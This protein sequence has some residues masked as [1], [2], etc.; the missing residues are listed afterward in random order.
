MMK[1]TDI[2]NRI[3]ISYY[4]TSFLCH[5][6]IKG[7]KWGVR[8]YQNPDGSYT[9]AGKKRRGTSS[10][11]QDFGTKCNAFL[12]GSTSAIR[13]RDA[14]Q[15]QQNRE[16]SALHR[17]SNPYDSERHLTKEA[18][19]YLKKVDTITQKY[20][21]AIRNLELDHIKEMKA[22]RRTIF[23]DP[24]I[25]NDVGAIRKLHSK[26]E[27]VERDTISENSELANQ[28][29]NSYKKQ[30]GNDEYG[31]YHYEWRE[32]NKAYDAANSRFKKETED[33]RKEYRVLSNRISKAIVN[34][35]GI[36]PSEKRSAME[37]VSIE[38]ENMLYTD[39]DEKSR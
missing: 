12:K 16:L 7:Q 19:D 34:A 17:P 1:N 14:L 20:D 36:S 11:S 35:S 30:H 13:K 37:R 3:L 33:I 31:F 23:G 6:G 15:V 24:S 29:F 2:Y 8:R 25:A 39:E 27:N 18:K 9:E 28:A 32:G 26:I 22:L 38:L 10:T 5:H 21:Q 4:D